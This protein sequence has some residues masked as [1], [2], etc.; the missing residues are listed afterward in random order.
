MKPIDSLSDE[1]WLQLVRRVV[2]MPD[3]PPQLVRSALEMWRQQRPADGAAPARQRW[4]AQLTFDSWAAAPLASG[5]RSLH[6]QVRSLV[7][8]AAALDVDLRIAPQDEA[9]SLGGQLLGPNGE[10]GVELTGLAGEPARSAPRVVPLSR[11]GEFRIDGVGQGTYQ[12]TLRL[13]GDEIVLSPIEVG[14]PPDHGG[15]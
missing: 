8:S 4:V 9:Y 2:T 11:F 5:M 13:G 15:R 12:L 7:F 1:E 6:S 10:G 14:L 3:V